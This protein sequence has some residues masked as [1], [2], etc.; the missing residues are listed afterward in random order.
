MGPILPVID[1]DKGDTHL[2]PKHKQIISIS[3]SVGLLGGN[4]RILHFDM[5]QLG[6][7]YCN[8]LIVMLM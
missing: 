4:S 5:D 8:E 1:S 6:L 2:S 3:I 7:M